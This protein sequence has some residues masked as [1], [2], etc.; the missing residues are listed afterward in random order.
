MPDEKKTE[1]WDCQLYVRTAPLKEAM[2][3][4]WWAQGVIDVRGGM[5]AQPKRKKRS[6]AGQSRTLDLQEPKK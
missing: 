5:E 1:I 3:F 6:D 2:E 4:V